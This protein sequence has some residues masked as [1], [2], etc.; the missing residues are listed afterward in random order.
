MQ[1]KV[2]KSAGL[3]VWINN[4]EM[5]GKVVSFPT[6]QGREPLFLLNLTFLLPPGRMGSLTHLLV[7][8]YSP[9]ELPGKRFF[10][11]AVVF[12]ISLIYT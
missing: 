12:F 3:I 4:P 5:F 11:I 2:F 1:Q 10:S 8:L 7:L 9:H 6:F